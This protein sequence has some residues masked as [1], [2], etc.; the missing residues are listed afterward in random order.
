MTGGGPSYVN[1]VINAVGAW[2]FVYINLGRE[3]TPQGISYSRSDTTLRAEITLPSRSL[4]GPRTFL[5]SGRRGG[6]EWGR[7]DGPRLARELAQ[8]ATNFFD[9]APA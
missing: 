3:I 9:S 8:I 4:L 1:S 6:G 5:I 2:V 7:G